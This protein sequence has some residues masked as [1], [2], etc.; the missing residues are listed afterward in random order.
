MRKAGNRAGRI[1]GETLLRSGSKIILERRHKE[2]EKKDSGRE[3]AT[4][5]EVTLTPPVSETSIIP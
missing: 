5:V 2:R 3:E 4:K 1:Q